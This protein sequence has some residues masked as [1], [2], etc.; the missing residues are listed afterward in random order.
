MKREG[1]RSLMIYEVDM[2]VYLYPTVGGIQESTCLSVL[3]HSWLVVY[4]NQS[5]RLYSHI[6]CWWYIGINLSVCTHT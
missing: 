4:R 1:N 3:T 2:Y 5:V 6:V